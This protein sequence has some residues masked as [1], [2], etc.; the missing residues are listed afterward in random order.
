MLSR[1]KKNKDGSL[2]LHVQKDSP[3]KGKDSNWPPAPDGLVY[4]V[5][6]LCWPKPE[7]P[8]VPPPG[9]GTWSPPAIA[10]AS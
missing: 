3:G 5:M 4:L 6:R 9:E 2:T 7:P 8:S 10:Q 1:M